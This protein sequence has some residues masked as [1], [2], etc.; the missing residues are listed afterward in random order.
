ME[1]RSWKSIDKFEQLIQDVSKMS[2]D[3]H[4]KSIEEYKGSCVCSTCATFNECDAGANEKL[5]ID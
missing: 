1:K 3:D 5:Y 2:P 4:N